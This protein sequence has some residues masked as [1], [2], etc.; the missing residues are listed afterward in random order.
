MYSVSYVNIYILSHLK[1]NQL[2]TKWKLFY[3]STIHMTKLLK[4]VEY[5]LTGTLGGVSSKSCKGSE[6]FKGVRGKTKRKRGRIC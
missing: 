5:I 2:H 6:S 3:L 4:I 1:E